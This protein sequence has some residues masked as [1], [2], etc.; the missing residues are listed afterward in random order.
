[1]VITKKSSRHFYRSV[2]QFSYCAILIVNRRKKG[3]DVLVRVISNNFRLFQGQWLFL[4]FHIFYIKKV[5]MFMSSN[6]K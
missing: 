4:G 1:M 5:K 2:K 6:R 3:R